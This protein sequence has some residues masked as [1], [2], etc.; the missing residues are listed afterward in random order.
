[1]LMVS[2]SELAVAVSADTVAPA[3]FLF[4]NLATWVAVMVAMAREA[5]ILPIVGRVRRGANAAT[6]VGASGVARK[7]IQLG[8]TFNGRLNSDHKYITVARK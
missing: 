7:K 3:L 1:M 8:R 2:A 4:F 6:F 5:D